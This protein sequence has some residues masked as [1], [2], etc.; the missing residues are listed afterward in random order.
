MVYK[1]S[2]P[3][4]AFKQPSH[5]TG[6]TQKRYCKGG[7]ALG[8]YF[9]CEITARQPE[10]ACVPVFIRPVHDGSSGD[11]L[12]LLD[13][14]HAEAWILQAGGVSVL[15]AGSEQNR[16]EQFASHSI[17]FYQQIGACETKGNRRYQH[18]LTPHREGTVGHFMRAEGLCWPEC[19]M[20]LQQ[21][22]RCSVM[23]VSRQPRTSWFFGRVLG[24]G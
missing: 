23:P 3:L 22:P 5:S 2:P 21:R 9:S 24:A 18:T 6:G 20:L 13:A 7:L 14:V 4:T 11:D 15:K 17:P 1:A 10:C 12:C 8:A 19:R 16:M